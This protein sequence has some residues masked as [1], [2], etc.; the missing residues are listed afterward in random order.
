MEVGIIRFITVSSTSIIT[1]A[2]A[3]YFL[4]LDKSEKALITPVIYKII[5]RN[6]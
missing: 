6:R 3:V 5:R 1:T 4:G 2:I